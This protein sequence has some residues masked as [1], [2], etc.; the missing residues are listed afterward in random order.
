MRAKEET[1]KASTCFNCLPWQ[2]IIHDIETRGFQARLVD[3]TDVSGGKDGNWWYSAPEVRRAGIQNAQIPAIR[4][5][6][7]PLVKS[8]VG[9]F[10]A[11]ESRV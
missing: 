4:S 9:Q 10:L 5:P 2:R 7:T 6:E 3:P 8:V 11:Q 1:V